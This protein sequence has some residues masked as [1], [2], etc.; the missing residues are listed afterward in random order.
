MPVVNITH[1]IPRVRNDM[2]FFGR[3]TLPNELEHLSE[4]AGKV[5]VFTIKKYIPGMRLAPGQK[6]PSTGKLHAEFGIA[7]PDK[8]SNPSFNPSNAIFQISKRTG[9]NTRIHVLIG[10]KTSYASYANSGFSVS[11]KRLVKF[12]NTGQI[13]WV[14]PFYFPGYNF[15]EK[16]I[17]EATPIVKG[18]Y[19]NGILKITP[20]FR[21]RMRNRDVFGRFK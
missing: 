8:T 1:N 5:V 19:R 15:A 21:A 7:E 9:R 13:R 2:V 6:R 10:T 3:V 11:S 20:Q 4:Q 14:R 18:I 17:A 16:G 12:T